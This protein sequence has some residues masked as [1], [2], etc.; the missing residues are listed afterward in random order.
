MFDEEPDGDPHG[1]CVA[2]ILRLQSLLGWAYKKLR[3]TQ[4][5]NID[6]AVKLDEMKLFLEH[7][8]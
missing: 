5:S 3:H 4:F 6:D 7:G 8:K 1:E 2:E